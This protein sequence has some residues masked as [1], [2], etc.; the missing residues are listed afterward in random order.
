MEVKNKISKFNVIDFFNVQND[1]AEPEFDIDEFKGQVL[2][3]LDTI[4]SQY[5]TDLLNKIRSDLLE[6]CRSVKKRLQ[7]D[8]LNEDEKVIRSKPLIHLNQEIKLR[9]IVHRYAKEDESVLYDFLNLV[10]HMLRAKLYESYLNLFCKFVDEIET[11][12]LNFE[13]VSS[14]TER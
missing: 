3:K 11:Q 12:I 4:N 6:L 13:K 1:A 2:K 14:G 7:H 8:E 9:K 10:Q 5:D